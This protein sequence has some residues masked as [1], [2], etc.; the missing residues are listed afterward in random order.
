MC[1]KIKGEQ[2]VE[3]ITAKQAYDRMTSG[4]SLVIIDVRT[5]EEYAGRHIEDAILIP[6]ETI[7]KERP[8]ELPDLDKEIL[9][10]CRSGYRSAIAAKKLSKMG[11]TNVKDF[12]GILDWTYG[13]VSGDW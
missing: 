7:G 3:T 1:E 9:V 4:D 8:E 2:S 6:N 10:Y 13:T 12:G 5:P 11:Y